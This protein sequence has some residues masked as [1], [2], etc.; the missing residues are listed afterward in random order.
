MSMLDL[1]RLSFP[2]LFAVSNQGGAADQG[3]DS[4]WDSGYARHGVDTEQVSWQGMYSVT[5]SKKR[6]QFTKT[7]DFDEEIHSAETFEH[8]NR[9]QA[10]AVR[11]E[12]CV[13]HATTNTE[14]G[15]NFFHRNL[16]MKSDVNS[17]HFAPKKILSLQRAAQKEVHPSLQRREK[18]VAVY[19]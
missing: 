5:K 1:S 17:K 15:K 18:I 4:P 14:T 12:D 10:I 13:D 11:N 19:L 9:F 6:R 2:P 16:M 8:K 3:C 7:T